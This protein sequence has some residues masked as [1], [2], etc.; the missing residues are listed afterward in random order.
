MKPLLIVTCFNRLEWTKKTLAELAQNTDLNAVDAHILDNG[1]ADGTPRWLKPWHEQHQST[2]HLM[3]ENIGCS[4]APNYVIERFRSPGQA[5]IKVDNDA[6]FK[7]AG[8]LNIW[9]D[10]LDRYKK[11]V[12][13]VSAWDSY[14]ARCEVG[15]SI[16][17][18]S[19]E[20]HFYSSFP[21]QFVLHTGE[22]MDRIG[23][24]DVLGP[25]HLYGFEDTIVSWKARKLGWAQVAVRSV[26]QNEPIIPSAIPQRELTERVQRTKPLWAKRM[27]IWQGRDDI[28]T[29]SD[30]TPRRLD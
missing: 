25:D 28:Y 7:T 16:K 8:W 17:V 5:V 6:G 21:G 2:L 11:P 27:Q 10:F 26:S 20:V 9:M 24:F 22:F 23:Y 13:M 3:P 30:G 19:H 29:D 4:R 18:G 14:L 15:A 1:S 12:A